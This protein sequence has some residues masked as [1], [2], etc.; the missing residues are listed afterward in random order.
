MEQT[1]T[2]TVN[3]TQLRDVKIFLERCELR[4]AEVPRFLSLAQA[5]G[6]AKVA[7]ISLSLATSPKV[8]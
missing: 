5:I 3:E 4:G 2:V 1:Y 7:E 8:E 6:Q